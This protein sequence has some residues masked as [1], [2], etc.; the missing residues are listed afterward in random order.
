MYSEVYYIMIN[1]IKSIALLFGLQFSK[2]LGAACS[3]VE[4]DIGQLVDRDA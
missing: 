3:I 2:F 4:Q 1:L